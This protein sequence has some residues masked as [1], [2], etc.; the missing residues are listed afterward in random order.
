MSNMLNIV[1][2]SPTPLVAAPSKVAAAQRRWGHDSV[3]IVLN[4][5]PEKSPLAKKF[6]EESLLPSP[7]LMS[8]IDRAI[9]NADIIHVHNELPA[10]W[11]E[12]LL[13]KNQSAKYVY[14]VHSPLREGPLYIER[15]NSI[16]LPFIGYFV[17]GQYQPRHYQK[18]LLVPNI[19]N[20]VPS[21]KFRKK[22][23]KLRVMFSPTHAQDGRWNNKHTPQLKDAIDALSNLGKIEPIWVD[24]PVHPKTLM[25]IRRNCH[26]SIDEIATGGFHQV[27]LEG[28]CAG[29]VVINRADFFSK[30]AFSQFSDQK[31]P[32]FCYSDGT[33]IA[34]FLLRLSA[35]VEETNYL[36]QQ[37]FEYFRSYLMPEQLVEKFNDAYQ[38]VI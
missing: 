24:T 33:Q 22:G 18:Y 5:Y 21:V 15:A 26:V 1:H 2:I 23:E 25:A 6:T 27:S 8:T 13:Q 31:L 17:V 10:D 11:V 37:S 14:Q 9:A 36:Q 34:D 38:S 7:F 20:E 30:A 28:L 32:P 4:D 16:G 35:D 19:V 3:S 29:N 12:N